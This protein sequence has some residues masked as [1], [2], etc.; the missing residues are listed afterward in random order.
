MLDFGPS[1]SAFGQ[2]AIFIVTV[3][4]V[5]PG[6][7]LPTGNTSRLLWSTMSRSSRPCRSSTATARRAWIRARCRSARTPSTPI[8]QGNGNFNGGSTASGPVAHGRPDSDQHD[9]FPVPDWAVADGVWPAGDLHHAGRA[10]LVQH[11]D[12][13]G[14]HAIH[15]R[16]RGPAGAAAQQFRRGRLVRQQPGRR[17][18]HAAG[19]L[20]RRRELCVQQHAHGAQVPGQSDSN[21]HDAVVVGAQCRH[22]PERDLHGQRRPRRAL[23]GPVCRPVRSPLPSTAAA[24]PWCRWNGIGH[25]R[26]LTQQ[27][28]WR[29]AGKPHHRRRPT[30]GG[31]DYA[32][33][34]ASLT[35][36]ILHASATT[37]SPLSSS[38]TASSASR[39]TFTATVSGSPR[40][41]PDRVGD[42]CGRRRQPKAPV[43]SEQRPTRHSSATTI[44]PA[45]A[46]Q[47]TPSRRP[48]TATA[49]SLPGLRYAGHAECRRGQ[50]QHQHAQLH[51]LADHGRSAGSVH[52]HDPTG[53]P[54]AE[55]FPMGRCSLSWMGQ[56]RRLCRAQRQRSS[57]PGHREPA[58]HAHHWRP[59]TMGTPIMWAATT[60]AAASHTVKVAS[61][62]TTVFGPASGI[63]Q[64]QSS[65]FMQVAANARSA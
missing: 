22:R 58:G 59:F 56:C 52:R 36:N 37:I 27:A 30:N 6:S 8:Y 18:A 35:E 5:A 63:Y 21:G 48:T 11:V 40:R 13:D 28:P 43:A 34:S 57:R 25:C 60:P 26:L 29:K 7:G 47:C 44:S 50:H 49:P 23:A 51:R 14:V 3:S 62:T 17:P 53:Y 15:P 54:R 4:P 39:S 38:P 55:T 20:R 64:K 24:P 46:R 65:L 41:H 12:A 45:T 9:R 19:G 33:S 31:T 1:P 32:T 61:T 10:R 16:R 42:V 2:M